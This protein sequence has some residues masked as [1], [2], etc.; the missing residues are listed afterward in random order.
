MLKRKTLWYIDCTSNIN[1]DLLYLKEAN[2]ISWSGLS[3]PPPSIETVTHTDNP[4][5]SSS[6][7][8][9]F[10]GRAMLEAQVIT[11]EEISFPSNSSP[12]A[13]LPVQ[14][15]S[16]HQ[17]PLHT[18]YLWKGHFQQLHSSHVSGERETCVTNLAGLLLL[19]NGL[20]GM[21]PSVPNQQ[22]GQKSVC[23]R[24][25]L[26]ELFQTWDCEGCNFLL[27]SVTVETHLW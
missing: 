21:D 8:K 26:W 20:H 18:I 12:A 14:G 11:G 6:I 15:C 7:N 13:P 1:V 24:E 25:Q 23:G 19:R 22:T 16:S 4:W 9:H 2:W 5:L 17:T 10:S 3:S 27:V